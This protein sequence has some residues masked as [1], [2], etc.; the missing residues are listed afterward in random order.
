MKTRIVLTAL[1]AAMVA[2]ASAQ[3][4]AKPKVKVVPGA[5][6]GAAP[7]PQNQP[8]QEDLKKQREEKLAKEVFK[9]APWS[10][11]YDKV[12]AEAKAGNKLIFTYFT[13][14]YAH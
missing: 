6:V 2:A 11:D 5:R 8:S 12:R 9:K 10:F 4:P 1:L 14:S 13:R 7:A 3:E